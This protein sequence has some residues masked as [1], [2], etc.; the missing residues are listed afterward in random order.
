[1]AISSYRPPPLYNIAYTAYICEWP[2]GPFGH[3]SS[4]V[5]ERQ[6]CQAKPNTQDTWLRLYVSV[7]TRLLLLF[8]HWGPR[9]REARH[10]LTTFEP[11]IGP[12]V[13]ITALF[14]LFSMFFLFV[15]LFYFLIIIRLPPS[16]FTPLF[17][18]CQGGSFCPTY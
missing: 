13:L 11:H 10:A 6:L 14:M 7:V 4:S 15:S 12:I 2:S 9:D 8:L 18:L 16:G 5:E 17:H 3:L 1:M